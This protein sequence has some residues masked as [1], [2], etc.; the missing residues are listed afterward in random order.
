M[1]SMIFVFTILIASALPAFTG[2]NRYDFYL[3]VAEKDL[4]A[5]GIPFCKMV[6]TRMG[7]RPCLAIR[8]ML[9]GGPKFESMAE[10]L[11]IK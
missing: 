5:F 3:A 1:L 9:P 4:E 10:V 8:D 11:E 2:E 7:M 6:E